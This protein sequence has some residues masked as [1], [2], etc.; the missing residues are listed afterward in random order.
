MN[1]RNE[2][3]SLNQ[4]KKRKNPAMCG[5]L[6]QYI[7]SFPVYGDTLTLTSNTSCMRVKEHVG[8]FFL[9]GVVVGR[10]FGFWRY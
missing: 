2:R 1:K 9:E 5:S 4:T 10:V 8:M 6:L 3:N 7:Y